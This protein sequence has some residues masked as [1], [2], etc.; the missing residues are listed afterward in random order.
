MFF[1]ELFVKAFLSL[2]SFWFVIDS[3][4]LDPNDILL[5][6]LKELSVKSF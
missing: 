6:D 5:R 3:H 4:A 1:G 2:P